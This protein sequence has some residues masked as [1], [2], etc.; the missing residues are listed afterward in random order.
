MYDTSPSLRGDPL[1][2]ADERR[3]LYE[4]IRTVSSTVDLEQVLA[5]V[6]RLIVEGVKAQSCF[7]WISD[8]DGGLVLRAASEQYA[9]AIGQTTLAPG[10][11]FAGWVA[12]HRQPIFLPS[13]ALADPRAHYFPEFEEEKYQSMVSVPLVGKDQAVFGVIGLHSVAPRTLTEDDAAF[14]IHSASLVAGAIENARLYEAT[15]RRVVELERLAEVSDSAAR[16]ARLEDLL[17]AVMAATEAL[18]VADAVHLYVVDG[19]RLVR[20]ASSPGAAPAPPVLAGM[21]GDVLAG[22]VFRG[23]AGA[24]IAAAPLAVDGEVLGYLLARSRRGRLDAGDRDLLQTVASQTAV[25]MRKVQLIEDL[26]ERHLIRDL[27]SDLVAGRIEGV[28]TR[29]KRLGCDLSMTRLA[30]VAVPWRPEQHGD[31][32]RN[33]AVEAFESELQRLIP[34][35]LLDRRD[36]V[37]RGIAPL[38]GG[39][40]AEAVRRLEQARGVLPVIVGVSNPCTGADAVALGLAEARQA[41]D[42]APVL[43]DRAGIVPYD[44]LGVYKYLLR[45]TDV[46][47]GRDRHRDALRALLA[48]DE[49]RQSDLART[50]EE[51]LARR[52]NIAATAKSLYVH[53]NTLRQRLRR[54]EELTGID[55][56]GDDTLMIEVALKLIRLQSALR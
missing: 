7:V 10:E 29:A 24:G 15:R 6:V 9:A 16:A 14:V 4:I 3:I 37:M 53:P 19:D 39:D 47:G 55:V 27:F 8:G 30:I 48:Y 56:R 36:D 23:A 20:R 26:T 42:A 5:A 44:G 34:G 54:I 49:R 2:P 41:V 25:G 51:F 31:V 1:A 18:L 43:G 40:E 35:V 45:V 13:D 28:V 22:A 46:P 12:E 32:A 33:A 50:L 21:P 11:G 17:P 52:C 38:P